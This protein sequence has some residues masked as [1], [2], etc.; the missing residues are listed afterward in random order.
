MSC[1]EYHKTPKRKLAVY[2]FGSTIMATQYPQFILD[3]GKHCTLPRPYHKSKPGNTGF[4]LMM[5]PWFRSFVADIESAVLYFLDNLLP[6][7]ELQQKIKKVIYYSK[8]Y[9]PFECRIGGSFFT[10]MSAIGKLKDRGEVPVHFDEK[11]IITT[12]VHLGEVKR[13]GST[14]YFDG[15]TIKKV[16]NMVYQIPFR[17]GQI[18]IGCFNDTL[19][20]A[21]SWSGNR[22]CLNFNLKQNVVDHFK[23]YRMRYFAS[24]RRNKYPQGIFFAT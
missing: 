23:T 10:H 22:G 21:E 11:D 24:Y 15:N 8:K 3:N 18:Q 20:R 6:D 2:C 19:H 4:E 16:G 1:G 13:G 5:Q 7:Q 9:V 17:H 12:L 14:Q